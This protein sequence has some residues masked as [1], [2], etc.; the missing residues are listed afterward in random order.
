MMIATDIK[1]IAVLGAGT[2]GPSLA[3]SYAKHGFEVNVW[4]KDIELFSL[5]KTVV[6]TSLHTMVAH[7]VVNEKEVSN[8]ISRIRYMETLTEAVRGAQYIVETIVE[9]REAKHQ[10]YAELDKLCDPEVIIAS[11][12]SALNIF[13]LM[14]ERR[15]P[16]T[17]IAHWFAPPHI[18]PLVEVVK[19]EK[20]SDATIQLT[21]EL[22]KTIDKAPLLI[23]KY[24]SGFVISRLLM[25]MN[26][27]I[28]YLL[29]NDYVSPEDLDAAVRSSLAPRMM[30]LGLVQRIDF[31]GLDMSARNC[32]NQSYVAPPEN[33]R[34][35][36]LFDR[37][38]KGELGVKSG[39]GFFD[40][41][42]MSTA[43][44]MQ[45][46]DEMLYQVF[47]CASKLDKIGN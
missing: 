21:M 18:I 11:N 35:A 43:E 44:I 13:E 1:R 37:V 24:L 2:M 31:T 10:L 45:K 20:T 17:I 41:S 30:A 4:S 12:T 5:A 15:L 9:N 14:V 40:Y 25:A 6:E 23:K 19:G 3:L 34:P 36:C 29:D 26:Q 47:Q 39:K 7:G 22:L 32:E 33:P 16:N 46:R 38:A 27:Q 42:G 8:I 28:W